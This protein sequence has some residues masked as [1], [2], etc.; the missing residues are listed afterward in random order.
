MRLGVTAEQAEW[1][2]CVQLTILG[3]M[4]ALQLS[5]WGRGYSSDWMLLVATIIEHRS[6]E[7]LHPQIRRRARNNS[8]AVKTKT[9][10]VQVF[11][12]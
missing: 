7:G 5:P 3:R 12:R 4:C 8:V 9:R 1:V 6:K 10:R 2:H 11:P